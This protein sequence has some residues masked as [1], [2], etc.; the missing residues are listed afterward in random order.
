R[1]PKIPLHKLKRTATNRSC[2][3][4]NCD[5]LK[6][7]RGARK[8]RVRVF[9]RA[10]ATGSDKSPANRMGRGGIEPATLGLKVG[11][12]ASSALARAVWIARLSQMILPEVRTDGTHLLTLRR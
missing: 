5:L 12:N 2:R 9:F 3:Q 6:P 1:G 7:G 11:L 8:T 4:W 10:Q